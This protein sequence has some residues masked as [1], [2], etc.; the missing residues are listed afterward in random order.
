MDLKE[1]IQNEIDKCKA[2]CGLTKRI[3][4][5]IKLT[6]EILN[7]TKFL[8]SFKNI[9]FSERVFCCYHNILSRPVC[10]ICR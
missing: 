6:N 9:T 1:Q 7:F 8:N 10:Q 4:K 5:N 3:N 2:M